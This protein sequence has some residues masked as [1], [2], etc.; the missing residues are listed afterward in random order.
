[1]AKIINDKYYT[2]EYI[3]DKCINLVK[4]HIS[5]ISEFLEPSAGNGAFSLK[6]ENC[7]AYDIEPEHP[8]II[9]QDFL[10]LELPYVKDRCI[11]GNP[12]F[13][14][15]NVL[16]QRFLNKSIMIGD[17]IAFI[18]PSSFHN[19]FS[20]FYKFDLIY[21]EDLGSIKYSD[22]YEVRTCFAIYKRPP[23]GLNKRKK[24]EFEKGITVKE[25][26]R[27]S[28]EP[29][30]ENSS[31]SISSWGGRTG[32]VINSMTVAKCIQFY[33]DDS[34]DIEKLKKILNEFDYNSISTSVRNLSLSKLS[35]IL[36][37]YSFK[38]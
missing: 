9:K 28:K 29:D 31:F 2:P 8:S 14:K 16:I 22:A 13:G 32:K 20:L 35:E 24:L 17:Y 1:M 26:R 5:N 38:K 6:L 19:S 36:S 12:P 33:C 21:S 30:F 4:C 3:V 34:I 27:G 11:I 10:T 15:S 7:K 23:Y 37:K 25:I 18:L